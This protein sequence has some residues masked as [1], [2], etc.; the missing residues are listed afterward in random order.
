MARGTAASVN[1]ECPWTEKPV[2][3]AALTRF[4]GYVVGFHTPEDRDAFERAATIAG[5]GSA[6]GAAGSGEG[7]HEPVNATCAKEPDGKLVRL[8]MRC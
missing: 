8:V 5:A 3:A 1:R 6:A 4:E 7:H 2:S